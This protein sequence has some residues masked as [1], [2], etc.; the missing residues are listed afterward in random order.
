M[1]DTAKAARRLSELK[2]LGVKLAID[3][4]GTGYSSLA[5]LQNFPVD[6][7]KIDRSFTN[8]LNSSPESRALMRTLVQLGR[9][10]GLKTLAEGVETTEQVD[11]LRSQHVNQA[12]GFLMARP[13]DPETLARTIL[14][15]APQL[16]REDAQERPGA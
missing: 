6:C 4:F 10:L 5:Y 12:Q 16:D 9:D 1:R 2:A 14:G 7:L 15:L 13:L 8:A 3:D 11:H